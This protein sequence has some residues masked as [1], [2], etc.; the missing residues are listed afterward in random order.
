MIFQYLT[1]V[2]DQTEL[3]GL[4]TECGLEG[5]RLHTCDSVTKVGS[6]GSGILMTFVVMDR[7]VEPEPEESVI[8]ESDSSSEGIIMRG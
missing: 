1:F 4:L 6:Q 8:D 2:C 5:W 3:Q 7:C